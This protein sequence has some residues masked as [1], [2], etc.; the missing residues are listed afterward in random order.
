[1][2]LILRLG[3]TDFTDKVAAAKFGADYDK[4]LSEV[5]DDLKKEEEKPEKPPKETPK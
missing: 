5:E 3:K 1:M 4:F 2:K